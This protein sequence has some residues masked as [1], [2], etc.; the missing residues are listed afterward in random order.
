MI[1]KIT[2]SIIV[3]NTVRLDWTEIFEQGVS[4][5]CREFIDHFVLLGLE[6]TFLINMN[7]VDFQVGLSWKWAKFESSWPGWKESIHLVSWV[8]F[9]KKTFNHKKMWLLQSWLWINWLRIK[10][11]L[12][13]SKIW[14]NIYSINELMKRR[15][16]DR[17]EEI[18][19]FEGFA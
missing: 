11:L 14:A 17:T 5:G 19:L 9:W 4:E 12:Q 2:I 1:S 8:Y 7:E 3:D 18:C 16:L 13:E 6:E 10:Y 15:F